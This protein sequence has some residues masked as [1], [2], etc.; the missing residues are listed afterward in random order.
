MRT[1]RRQLH[2]I[3]RSAPKPRS[4]L[5]AIQP[6]PRPKWG[7]SRGSKLPL[8]TS[9]DRGDEPL[10]RLPVTPRPPL[11]V[12]RT[13]DSPRLQVVSRAVRAVEREPALEFET[14]R[15]TPDRE[16]MHLS[17]R[18][19]LRAARRKRIWMHLSPSVDR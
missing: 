10:I 14:A 5:Q 16:D 9:P 19:W 2:L 8:F 1:R 4:R 18:Y 11:A 3:G 12:R 6:C 15:A 13:P 17:R 7:R